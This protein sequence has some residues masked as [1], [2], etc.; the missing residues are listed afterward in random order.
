MKS[1]NLEKILKEFVEKNE[2][3]SILINGPWGCGKTYEANKFIKEQKKDNNKVYYISLFGLE[4][5]DEINT[6]LYCATQKHTNLAK[7]VLKTG[8]FVLTKAIKAIPQVS[9]FT[10]ALDYQLSIINDGSKKKKEI[11]KTLIIFDDIERLSNKISYSDLL[12]YMNALFLSNC[13]FVCLMSYKNVNKNRKKDFD[14]FKEKVFDT[15]YNI[16]ESN[17]DALNKIFSNL[18]FSLNTDV[19][20]LFE[21]NIRFARKTKLFYDKIESHIVKSKFNLENIS[22]NKEL[23]LKACIYTINISLKNFAKDE[24]DHN[25]DYKF[26][27]EYFDNDIAN[28]IINIIK[29][30][31]YKS[32]FSIPN[33]KFLVMS[34]L[35]VFLHDDYTMF[36]SLTI[37]VSDNKT[38][39][40]LDK[41]F[42][43]LSDEHKIEYINEFKNALNDKEFKWNGGLGRILGAIL[44]D[45]EVSFNDE[46]I[47]SIARYLVSEKQ[48]GKINVKWELNIY[49]NN[50]IISKYDDLIKKIE[51]KINEIKKI[52]YVQKLKEYIKDFN[53]NEL[54]NCVSELGTCDTPEKQ[55]ALKYIV[56]NNFLIPDISGDIDENLW[57]YCHSIARFAKANDKCDEFIKY[58]KSVCNK[59]KSI[60]EIDRFY[61]LIYYNIDSNFKK[62]D[63]N[64]MKNEYNN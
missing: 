19:Y 64:N 29:N 44:N 37:D 20:E 63:L 11:K 6:E 40:I 33:F 41:T 42:F 18:D 28:G 49:D 32:D 3:K 62:N 26:Y 1:N 50:N 4:S 60:S 10:T 9:D 43:Y 12:G 48:N 24:G 61:A 17:I 38:D 52:D 45:S 55:E 8:F 35:K 58:A 16:N 23:L 13:R 27:N 57:S 22:L 14:D 30:E 34:L 47:A 54:Y 51:N 2:Y 15:I 53:Y 31:K 56:D 39:Y 36:D 21:M 5:I 59:A 46:E 7:R 25:K